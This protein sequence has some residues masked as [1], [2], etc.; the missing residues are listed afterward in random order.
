[1]NLYQM[2]DFA[3]FEI[4]YHRHSSR[5]HTYL[6]KKVAVDVAPELLQEVFEKLHKSRDKYASQYPFLPWLFTIARNTV[7]DFFK[8]AETKVTLA[9]KSNPLLLENLAVA[10]NEASFN[11]NVTE[12]LNSLP[13][14]QKRATEL[15]YM[16]DWSFEK[17]AVSMETSEENV[18]KIISRGIKKIRSVFGEKGGL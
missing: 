12:A 13:H 18:R 11:S 6:K 9:S 1:M 8:K 14:D 17:I 10:T 16:S 5:V 4:L 2:G 7:T 15:R 3:A